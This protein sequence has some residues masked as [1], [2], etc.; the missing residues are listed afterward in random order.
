[1]KEVHYHD[2]LS[3]PVMVRKHEDS[4]RMCIYFKDLDKAFP[5][6]GYPLPEIDWK[7]ESMCGLP[8][9]YFMDAYKA[10]HQIQMVKEDKK[11]TALIT[12]Q[13]IF[14]YTKMPFGLRNAGATYQRLVDKGL[15]GSRNKLHVDG[16]VSVVLGTCQEA[17]KQIF[18]STPHHSNH[19]PADTTVKGQILSDFIV[20]RPEKDSL[21]TLMGEEEL[22]KPWILFTDGSSYTDGSKAGLILINPEGMKFTYALR[23]RFDATK[24]EAEY[25]ALISGLKI[26]E[27]MGV[28]N[29]QA[30]VDSRGNTSGS[31]RRRYMDDSYF[32]IPYGMN[33][34]SRDE[35]SKGIHK[36]VPRNP[37]Q[38]LSPITSL[39]PFYKWG[40][41]IAG[42]FPKGPEKVKFLIVAIDYFTKWIKAKPVATITGNQIKNS[43]G[44]TS[45]VD[46]D[47]QEKLSRI[48]ESSSKTTHSRIGAR[49][50]VSA[51]ILLLLNIRKPMA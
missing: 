39:W 11:K 26:A 33:I 48:M 32:Q 44:I 31:R 38:K 1:M 46:S 6:D 30:N 21:D 19:G 47:S 17:P 36:P 9:K 4:W 45:F 7:V 3:N 12:S 43:C 35:K 27:Q 20:E 37:Q 51:N 29:L 23:F 42:P 13:G 28:K 10:Y 16:K 8:F 25:E 50:Y 2:W 24:N 18:P 5:K 14:C 34:A 40:I 15:K 41:D 49:N 22:P